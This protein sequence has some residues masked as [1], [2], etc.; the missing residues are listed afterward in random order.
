[1]RTGRAHTYDGTLQ[2]AVSV[3]GQQP[4]APA[5]RL[6]G[7]EAGGWLPTRERCQAPGLNHVTEFW[8]LEGKGCKTHTPKTSA[9]PCTLCPAR[10]LDAASQTA[11]EG[12]SEASAGCWVRAGHPPT[13]RPQWMRKSPVS[14]TCQRLL[15][16][17]HHF[18]EVT[19]S[20]GGSAKRTNGSRCSHPATLGWTH[21]LPLNK[22]TAGDG[23]SLET[24]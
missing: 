5:P 12:G 17:L 4:A 11:L 3:P 23:M 6:V 18:M 13:L 1:M 9:W 16:K 10:L 19:L 14:R 8:P 22:D 7:A 21:L 20:M 2:R 15:Q 24:L